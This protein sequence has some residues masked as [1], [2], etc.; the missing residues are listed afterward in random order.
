MSFPVAK[1]IPILFSSLITTFCA[2]Q[3]FQ[4]PVQPPEFDVKNFNIFGDWKCVKHDYRGLEK[5][6]GQQADAIRRSILHIEKHRYYFKNINFIKTC[7]FYRWKVTNYIPYDAGNVLERIYTPKQLNEIYLLATV[8]KDDNEVCY[9][10]CV[11]LKK[12][13]FIITNCGGYFFY[14]VRVK[15]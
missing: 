2:A 6:S 12:G 15:Q 9:N 7:E 14:W 13:K 10:E 4:P 11:I 8:D 5:F 1:L 3:R